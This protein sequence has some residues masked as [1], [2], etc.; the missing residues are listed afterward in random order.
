MRLWLCAF[1]AASFVGCTKD[2]ELSGTLDPSVAEGEGFGYLAVSIKTDQTRAD[3]DIPPM[4]P[5][6]IFHPGEENEYKLTSALNAHIAIFFDEKKFYFGYSYLTPKSG[7]V[8]DAN[9]QGGNAHPGESGVGSYGASEKLYT[10]ITRDPRVTNAAGE[11]PKY[12][13]VV[14]NV[15]PTRIENIISRLVQEEKT[16]DGTGKVYKELITEDEDKPLEAGLYH[17]N[18]EYFFTMTN[19]AYLDADGT[20]INLATPIEDTKIYESAEKAAADP[21]II[22]VERVVAKYTLKFKEGE[23]IKTFEDNNEDLLFAPSVDDPIKKQISYVSDFEGDGD[24]KPVSK[25]WYINVKGWG[26]NALETSSYYFKNIDSEDTK[27]AT[28][29]AKWWWNPA[30]YLHRSYWAHDPHYNTEG[31]KYP[32]QYVPLFTSDGNTWAKDDGNGKLVKNTN[33][34]KDFALKYLPYKDMIDKYKYTYSL[35]NT[36]SSADNN[37]S[38]EEAL[39]GYNPLRYGT[40]V[41]IAAEMI[42]SDESEVS[43]VNVSENQKET[44]I[45]A[46]GYFWNESSYIHWVYKLLCENV[47][48]GQVDYSITDIFTKEQKEINLLDNDTKFLFS[49]VI[50]THLWVKGENDEEMK[51][52]V[53]SAEYD[54]SENPGSLIKATTVFEL[55]KA[56]F[57]YGDGKCMLKVKTGYSVYIKYKADEESEEEFIEVTPKNFASIVCS[58]NVAPAGAK[59][60]KESKMYYAVPIRHYGT[61]QY[62]GENVELAPYKTDENGEA[63]Q[64][65]YELGD[66]G[67]VR[68]HWYQL[69]VNQ[70]TKPGTPVE[71]PDDPIVPND[72]EYY[73]YIGVELVI[74]PWH[75]IDQDVEL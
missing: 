31:D 64:G 48:N 22:Y 54:A 51:Q 9:H 14:L 69:T 55:G 10:Y 71:D 68:N 27:S 73:D 1:I 45:S 52:V 19:S 66:F 58:R 30:T 37:E 24:V 15:S 21:V 36:Y 13:L 50:D 49:K 23:N 26:V 75:V 8:E 40:H 7:L 18:D 34:N 16:S 63:I 72:P 38:Y 3:L 20:D 35:E 12:V 46:D 5:G 43:N 47:L 28:D 59:Y 4:A 32:N 56:Y 39:Q 25:Y 62:R 60:Y 74:L 61:A 29:F 17:V 65:Q 11:K 41:V 57:E 6:E 42:L 2:A 44:I 33:E 67:V 53:S 70:F